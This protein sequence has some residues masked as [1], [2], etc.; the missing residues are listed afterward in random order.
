MSGKT[1][2]QVLT[3]SSQYRDSPS[4]YITRLPETDSKCEYF[5]TTDEGNVTGHGRDLIVVNRNNNWNDWKTDMYMFRETSGIKLLMPC[6]CIPIEKPNHMLDFAMAK[7][8]DL[9]TNKKPN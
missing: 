5:C 3:A 4:Q 8:D 2:V 1:H 9:F 6:T 7:N